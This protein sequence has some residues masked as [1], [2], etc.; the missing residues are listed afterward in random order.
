MNENHRTN[1]EWYFTGSVQ[2]FLE[3]CRWALTF[4]QTNADGDP[5]YDILTDEEECKRVAEEY[6]MTLEAIAREMVDV[7]TFFLSL[8]GKCYGEAD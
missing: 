6:G 2:E 7:A 5:N 3:V 1:S 8:E 4:W